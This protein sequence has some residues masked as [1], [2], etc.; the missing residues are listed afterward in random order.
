MILSCIIGV[1]V[2][3]VLISGFMFNIINLFKKKEKLI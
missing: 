1:I 2:F 3:F